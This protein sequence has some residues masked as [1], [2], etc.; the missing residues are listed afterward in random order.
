MKTGETKWSNVLYFTVE[1]IG[2]KQEQYMPGEIPEK[3]LWAYQHILKHDCGSISCGKT[4][5]QVIRRPRSR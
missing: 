3:H 2:E 1:D 5:Y 4:V